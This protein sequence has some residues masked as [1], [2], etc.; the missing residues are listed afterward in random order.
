MSER[1]C[2]ECNEKVYLIGYSE[3]QCRSCSNCW[4]RT[5]LE[6]YEAEN[7]IK[8]LEIFVAELKEE[9]RGSHADSVELEKQLAIDRKAEI[10]KAMEK[11][12]LVCPKVQAE[13][14][15][16][17]TI[18]TEVVEGELCYPQTILNKIANRIRE[19]QLCMK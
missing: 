3:W 6:L 9:I 8:E 15:L 18:V 16:M 5:S 11:L 1:K 4:D 2:P 7:R 14:E 12:C 13:R 10:A 17:F 19:E